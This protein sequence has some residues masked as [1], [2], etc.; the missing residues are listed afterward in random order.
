MI[1][2]I[3]G[4]FGIEIGD[5]DFFPNFFFDRKRFS[6]KKKSKIVGRKKCRKMSYE[7]VNEK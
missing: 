2:G 7:K 4:K 5:R 3:F 1:F 6:S